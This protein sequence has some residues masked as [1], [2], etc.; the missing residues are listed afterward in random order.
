MRLLKFWLFVWRSLGRATSEFARFVGWDMKTVITTVAL[1]G[2]G[3]FI[4]WKVK[5][6]ADTKDELGKYALLIFIHTLSSPSHCL[7]FNF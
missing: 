3:Y 5:G 4:Y 7:P 2:L 1:F 6:A